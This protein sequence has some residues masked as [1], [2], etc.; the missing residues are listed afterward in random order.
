M[1]DKYSSSFKL[2]S[3]RCRVLSNGVEDVEAEAEDL[4]RTERSVAIVIEHLDG[5][6]ARVEAKLRQIQ[7]ELDLIRTQKGQ[8]EEMYYS[9]KEKRASMAESV[10]LIERTL[11]PLTRDRD[12]AHL[13]L[14]KLR[15]G[16]LDDS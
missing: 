13:L 9:C 16:L 5:E 1:A 12:K 11:G 2:L 7:K 15:P 8:Q 6:E 14:K 3:K 4:Q 10:M